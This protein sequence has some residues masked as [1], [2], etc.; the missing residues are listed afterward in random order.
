MSVPISA[1]TERIPINCCFSGGTKIELSLEAGGGV[2]P[3]APDGMFIGPFAASLFVG[4]AVVPAALESSSFTSFM[5]QIGQF[6]GLSE[7]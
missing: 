7:W 4:P 3:G 1:G 5:L 2:V 6:P